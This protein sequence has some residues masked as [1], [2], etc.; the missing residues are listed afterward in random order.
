MVM[1]VHSGPG[2]QESS[3]NLR[4]LPVRTG[5]RSKEVQARFYVLEA[6]EE[7]DNLI[8]G[9]NMKMQRKTRKINYIKVWKEE[10][11]LWCKQRNCRKIW[12]VRHRGAP[13][14]CPYNI[15]CIAYSTR[16]FRSC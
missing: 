15:L 6:T 3:K 12:A 8:F 2:W 7:Y 9:V 13:V 10:L 1:R 4:F 16:L 11:S 14:F 5:N